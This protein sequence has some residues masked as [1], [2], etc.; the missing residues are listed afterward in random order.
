MKLKHFLLLLFLLLVGCSSAPTKR[1]DKLSILQGVTSGNE[2]EFSVVAPSGPALKF[3]LRSADG[4]VLAPD[5]VKLVSRGSS[6]WVVHKMIFTRDP[7]RVYNFYVFEGEKVLDQ[8]LVGKG[9]VDPDRL[10]MAVASGLDQMKD[11]DLAI[12]DE[13]QRQ[14]PE[15]LLLIGDN[16]YES[17]NQKSK[18]NDPEQLWERYLEVR[19]SLPLFFQEKLIPVHALWDDLDF[20]SVKTRD[21]SKEI[22]DAFWA[23]NMAEDTWIS[24]PGI[25]GLLEL[26]DFNLYFLDARS[27]RSENATGKALGLDQEAWLLAKLKEQPGPSLLIKG[28]QFFGGYHGGDSFEGS[29]PGDFVQFTQALAKLDTPFLFLSGDRRLSE[30]MQFPRG[31]FKKPSFEITASP[32]HGGVTTSPESVNPWR[33]VSAKDKANFL[34]IKNVAKDDHWF[35]DVESIG[36]DGRVLFRRELAVYI[37]D[38][39]DNLQE[40]RKKRR[41]G[42]RRYRRK[43]RRRRR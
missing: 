4:G 20:G 27:W 28:D 12:W 8:R 18:S 17:Q 21:A 2:V 1:T 3:E 32:V 26:G 16:V 10:V 29:H 13:V 19:L 5:E 22:F 7:A 24:G 15:Y 31:L 40:V 43:I 36:V 30:I 25:G 35:L 38:L 34:L 11:S 23:Q 9:A 14:H 33:V 37:K 42:E 41:S 6:S 39:Q